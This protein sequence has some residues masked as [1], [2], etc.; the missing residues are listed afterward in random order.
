MDLIIEIL[1]GIV[2]C[3]FNKTKCI[4]QECFIYLIYFILKYILI[5]NQSKCF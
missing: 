5:E 3:L 2:K 1:L 4:F